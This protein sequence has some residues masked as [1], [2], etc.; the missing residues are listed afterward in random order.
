M[1]KSNKLRVFYGSLMIIFCLLM[2]LPTLLLD[3]SVAKVE[4]GFIDL[5]EWAWQSKEL[6][7]LNG[8]WLYQDTL[9]FGEVADTPAKEMIIPS[10]YERFGVQADAHKGF[11]LLSL[12]IDLPKQVD[13][14]GLKFEYIG[15]A[16]TVYVNG[17]EMGH[18]GKISK[19]PSQARELYAPLTVYFQGSGRTHIDI[20]FQ[21][22]IDNYS[23]IKP[24]KI[25]R[26]QTVALYNLLTTGLDYIFTALVFSLGAFSFNYFI[27]RP[28]SK[29]TLYFSALC[30]LFSIRGTVINQRLLLQFYPT[31][32]WEVF[33]RLG[34]LPLFLGL[35]FFIKYFKN[36]AP[37]AVPEKLERIVTVV[38]L[39]Q[40]ACSFFVPVTFMTIFF[41]PL[42][43]F[44]FVVT[45][46]CILYYLM[47]RMIKRREE[48]LLTASV[49][50]L[51]LVL[52][53][54]IVANYI[55]TNLTYLTTSGLVLFFILQAVE[56]SQYFSRLLENV[57]GVGERNRIL[58]EELAVLN[59]SLENLVQDRTHDLM[60]KTQELEMS[61]MKLRGLNK[62][63]ENLSFID[64]LTKVPNRRMFF[65]EIDKNFYQAQRENHAMML[66]IMDIDYFKGYNDLY[67]HVKGDWCLFNIA[68]TVEQ[69]ATEHGFIM[70]RYGGEEFIVAGFG[71]SREDSIT[72]GES[73]QYAIE[74]MDIEHRKSEVSDQVTVSIG[75]VH[76]NLSQKD[77]IM[78]YVDKADN[79]L[80]QAKASGR[81]KFFI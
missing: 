42:T 60:I 10:R 72:F 15:T 16:Y 1:K 80:Y 56:L 62:H 30:I 76:V 49:I 28:Q 54:D 78:T 71:V 23:Y 2:F 38:T 4:D 34:Y 79:L 18:I 13:T 64:E 65:N 8:E 29:E 5:K 57:E 50:F 81:N 74:E 9:L 39:G 41:I 36:R 52:L 11:G 31:M 26:S 48:I 61:N 68:Q 51:M 32:S 66:M 22:Y 63:L 47:D 44:T 45:I 46:L 19:D 14:Y 58:A 77:T 27:L 7:S 73:I 17:Q 67:G 70:A 12:E 69:I 53:N 24:V 75:A 40:A 37:Y 3:T 25:G 6:I 59:E 20:E 33:G 35:Y 21:N 43:I 55:T